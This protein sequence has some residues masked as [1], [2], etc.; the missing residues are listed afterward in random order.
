MA[1]CSRVFVA[2]ILT[3]GAL[4][5]SGCSSRYTYEDM[6]G[7]PEGFHWVVDTET[8]GRG[9]ANAQDYHVIE[10]IYTEVW[11]VGAPGY[12]IVT[13][14][15]KVGLAN[16]EK[17]VV[18]APEHFL[19][20]RLF[21]N[22][23]L[24]KSAEGKFGALNA[25]A[26]GRLPVTYASLEK[27]GDGLA[28][29]YGVATRTDGGVE[30]YDEAFAALLPKETLKD[31]FERGRGYAD[32]NPGMAKLMLKVCDLFEKL[33]PDRQPFTKGEIAG[34]RKVWTQYLAKLKGK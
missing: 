4:A 19:V 25:D 15:K 5:A 34:W 23:L 28:I 27:L 33:D 8:G 16:L 14:D 2:S 18:V 24:V 29:S 12:Q 1:P 22:A 11:G 9:V 30:I 10:P 20:Q 6:I 26:S 21:K 13:R 32:G 17:G 3:L 31:A 7:A